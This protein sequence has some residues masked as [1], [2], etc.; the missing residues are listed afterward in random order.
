MK[1][2]ALEFQFYFDRILYLPHYLLIDLNVI[3]VYDLNHFTDNKRVTGSAVAGKVSRFARKE[4]VDW[5][6]IL[7]AGQEEIAI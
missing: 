2:I 7:L 3:C 5:C 4:A 1:S 6:G